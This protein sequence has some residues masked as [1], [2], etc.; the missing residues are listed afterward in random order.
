MMK[1]IKIIFAFLMLAFVTGCM[2][3]R[4]S[5]V[6]NDVKMEDGENP[7]CTIQIENTGWFLFDVIPLVCGDPRFPNDWSCRFF[8][9]TITL[10]NNL[11]VLKKEMYKYKTTRIANVNSLNK[12]NFYFCFLLFRRAC[13]TSAVL[14]E[15]KK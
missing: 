8:T 15:E 7:L 12:D 2:T 4:T 5:S 11:K 3:T 1:Y 6:Y 9:N 13:L 10:E 14:L